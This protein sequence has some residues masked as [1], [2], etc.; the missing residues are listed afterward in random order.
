MSE[1][2]LDSQGFNC[3]VYIIFLYT[4]ESKHRISA[5]FT[6]LFTSVFL[7]P[8]FTYTCSKHFLLFHAYRNSHSLSS[9]VLLIHL[10]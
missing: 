2:P 8:L 10:T 1:F 7:M 3:F 5:P 4:D 9:L 6:I